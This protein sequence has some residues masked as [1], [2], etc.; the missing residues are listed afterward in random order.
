MSALR[1]TATNDAAAGS[2]IAVMTNAEDANE[3]DALAVLA[4][5]VI[6]LAATVGMRQTQMTSHSTSMFSTQ[7]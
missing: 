7:M 1:H 4:L 2:R 5:T 6:A 3:H